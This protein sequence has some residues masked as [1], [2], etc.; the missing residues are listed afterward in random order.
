V[1]VVVPKKSLTLSRKPASK[2]DDPE[3]FKRF[4][5]TAPEVE[6]SDDP[7]EFDDAIK[8]VVFPKEPSNR[9]CLGRKT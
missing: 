5:E 6:A 2:P 4:I 8:R 9:D 7:K 1:V 3:E